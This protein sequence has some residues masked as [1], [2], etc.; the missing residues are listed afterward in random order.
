[1]SMKYYEFL[2][3]IERSF[4]EMRSVFLGKT[5]DRYA[6][7][8]KSGRSEIRTFAYFEFGVFSETRTIYFQTVTETRKWPTRVRAHPLRKSKGWCSSAGNN[9]CLFYAIS[10]ALCRVQGAVAA[11]RCTHRRC[12][13]C[14]CRRCRLPTAS[15]RRCSLP[16]ASCR[17]CSLPTASF[18]RCSLLKAT[19]AG[20]RRQAATGR[21]AAAD[22][23]C[24]GYSCCRCRV[25][26][27]Q[28]GASAS[29]VGAGCD[30]KV[31]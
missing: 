22:E 8:S 7:N 13:R 19:C 3:R 14:R 11:R 17:R 6:P 23:G 24:R 25:P 28:R 16:T 10:G 18:R 4:R 12:R 26:Q 27:A 20:C 21:V 15:Y 1:M 5:Y 31:P 2:R 30:G 9:S 29:A